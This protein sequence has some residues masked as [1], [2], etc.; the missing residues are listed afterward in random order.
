[1]GDHRIENQLPFRLHITRDPEEKTRENHIKMP[2]H[3]VHGPEGEERVIKQS[4]EEQQ[5]RNS[6][7]DVAGDEPCFGAVFDLPL[8][9][10]GDD[11]AGH[12]HRAGLQREDIDI[13]SWTSRYVE[14]GFPGRLDDA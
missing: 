14:V 10:P 2:K 1:M 13:E 3:G 8:G 4:A 9:E 6:P 7:D 12:D 11:R 5:I